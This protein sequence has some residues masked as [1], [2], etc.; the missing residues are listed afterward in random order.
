MVGVMV[1]AAR[2]QLFRGEN[3]KLHGSCWQIFDS[4]CGNFAGDR[5][6]SF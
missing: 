5:L 3:V 4:F 6:F 1:I 2:A